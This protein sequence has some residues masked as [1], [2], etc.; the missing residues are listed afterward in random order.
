MGL[1]TSAESISNVVMFERRILFLGSFP[2]LV[3][4]NHPSLALICNSF[5]AH[6]TKG[7]LNTMNK[8]LP[9]LF[10]SYCTPTPTNPQFSVTPFS[11][12]ETPKLL[13]NI[14]ILQP[15]HGAHSNL[16]WFIFQITSYMLPSQKMELQRHPW[17]SAVTY[18]IL[19]LQST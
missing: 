13:Y 14:S 6:N 4:V 10:L 1:T 9:L 19:F 17:T 3:W 12:L 16:K 18:Y 11:S 15:Q 5:R 7:P 2:F 8:Y